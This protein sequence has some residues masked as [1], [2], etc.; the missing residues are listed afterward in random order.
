M[1]EDMPFGRRNDLG[2]CVQWHSRI[3]VCPLPLETTPALLT[4]RAN[5]YPYAYGAAVIV[6]SAGPMR[7]GSLMYRL[8][9]YIRY[10]IP[11]GWE[12]LF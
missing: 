11:H 12:F 9:V 1:Q 10:I 7:Q 8:V 2:I 4:G 6:L 3:R 5:A